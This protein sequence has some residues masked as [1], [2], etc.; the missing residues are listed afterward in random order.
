MINGM[1]KNI[2]NR[3]T[4]INPRTSKGKSRIP[5]TLTM[6]IA[7]YTQKFSFTPTAQQCCF[8]RI[9]SHHPFHPVI[10]SPYP[11]HTHTHCYWLVYWYWQLVAVWIP[12]FDL[13]FE[14]V[15]ITIGSKDGE[16]VLLDH[17]LWYCIPVCEHKHWQRD[18]E[19]TIHNLLC[20]VA[21]VTMGLRY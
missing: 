11:T 19:K 5:I 21:T 16:E 13:F 12:V 9:V 4:H 7:N 10:A 14:T 6:V 15:I 8:D 2:K 17:M 3:S 18:R 20:M 1:F